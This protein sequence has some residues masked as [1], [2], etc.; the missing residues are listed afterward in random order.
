MNSCSL[1]ALVLTHE[2]S[3]QEHFDDYLVKKLEPLQ[4]L[5]MFGRSGQAAPP[6][7]K[8]DSVY[9]GWKDCFGE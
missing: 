4:P 2:L 5:L 6:C 7:R 9:D 3:P 8:H 1:Q